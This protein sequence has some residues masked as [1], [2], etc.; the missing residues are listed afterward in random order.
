MSHHHDAAA[1]ALVL[2]TAFPHATR[3]QQDQMLIHMLV[4]RAA[5]R[6]LPRLW[7]ALAQTVRRANE[8]LRDPQTQELLRAVVGEHIDQDLLDGI[9][10]AAS[11]EPSASSVPPA[12]PHECPAFISAIRQR[13]DAEL[14]E[15]VCEIDFHE[16]VIADQISV[17]TGFS[18]EVVRV[19]A[20]VRRPQADPASPVV[21]FDPV[22][23]DVRRPAVAQGRVALGPVEATLMTS[24]PGF[25]L[26]LT[27]ES[28]PATALVPV[29]Q[30]SSRDP[31]NV[32]PFV[33]PEPEPPPVT[34]S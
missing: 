3:S 13:Y 14:H 4:R 12:E 19:N 15:C 32:I 21:E 24:A 16:A 8:A 11:Q 28:R 2:A 7:G 30:T 9:L 20:A 17:E 27:E 1:D 34:A 22:W 25:T 31:D 18:A 5:E 10:R 29:R 6:L 26:L 33:R 23:F